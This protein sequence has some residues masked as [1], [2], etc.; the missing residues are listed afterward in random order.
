MER[1]EAM[2][3]GIRKEIDTLK[4]EQED[5]WPSEGYVYY[6]ARS[7]GLI[8]N[9]RWQGSEFENN[10]K[11]M[12]NMYKTEAEASLATQKRLI[13]VKLQ[14]LADKMWKDVGYAINWSNHDQSKLHVVFD[15]EDDE[16]RTRFH[17][18]NQTQGA[19]FLPLGTGIEDILPVVTDAELR[20]LMGVNT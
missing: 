12:G 10:L 2:L 7:D 3:D 20:V 14:K 18:F 6:Y 8:F 17:Q 4:L 16:F 11:S 5:Q 9:G 1:L 13:H 19:V 15:H